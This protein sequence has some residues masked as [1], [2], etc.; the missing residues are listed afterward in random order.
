MTKSKKLTIEERGDEICE[1]FYKLNDNPII[2]LDGT[3]PYISRRG[4][5]LCAIELVK[6]SIFISSKDYNSEWSNR[7]SYFLRIKEYLESK[8]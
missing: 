5:I 8:L 1:R 4:S 2:E 7:R 6:E 3:D